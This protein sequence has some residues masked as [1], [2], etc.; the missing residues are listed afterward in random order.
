M[1]LDRSGLAEGMVR[2]AGWTS[3]SPRRRT[4]TED[5]ALFQ[6]RI[7]FLDQRLAVGPVSSFVPFPSSNAKGRQPGMSSAM[8]IMMET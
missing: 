4:A 2:D 3:F 8:I 6:P 5:R 7:T 1:V